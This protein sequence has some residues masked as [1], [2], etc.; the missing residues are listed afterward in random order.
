MGM[1][2]EV[3]K[4]GRFLCVHKWQKRR[5]IIDERIINGRL[6]GVDI[7]YSKCTKCGRHIK[8]GLVYY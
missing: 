7:E 4:K 5:K 8:E 3:I 1:H 2:K 6:C